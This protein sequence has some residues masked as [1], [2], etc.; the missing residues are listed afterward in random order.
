[1]TYTPA[2]VGPVLIDSVLRCRLRYKH[3]AVR[4]A[5]NVRRFSPAYA[6]ICNARTREPKGVMVPLSH[7]HSLLKHSV[8]LPLGESKLKTRLVFQQKSSLLVSARECF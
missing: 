2:P 5:R 4:A 6:P 8:T 3:S 7:Q 1:M